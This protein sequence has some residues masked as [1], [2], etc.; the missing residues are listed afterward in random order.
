MGL[1]EHIF[2]QNEEISISSTRIV[3]GNKTIVA[4]AICTIEL[5]KEEVKPPFMFMWFG[6]FCLLVAVLS[7][8]SELRGVGWFLAIL[9]LL[10]FFGIWINAKRTRR[11]AVV[12]ELSSGE[13]EYIDYKE[14]EDLQ[15]VFNALNQVVIFR[16]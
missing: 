6:L 11:E 13:R 2:L 5:D 10:L 16:G 4:S 3:I 15:E 12:I 7:P 9:L 14:V 1:Q 8:Y